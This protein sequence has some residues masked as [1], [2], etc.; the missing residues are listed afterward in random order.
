MPV[1][2]TTHLAPISA[3]THILAYSLGSIFFLFAQ[4]NILCTVITRDVRVTKYYLAILA[5]GDIGHL[6]ANYKGMGP[7]VFWNFGDYNEVMFGNV[8]IT[9]FLW[10]NRIATLAGVFGRVGRRG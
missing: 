10:V 7:N 1:T 5:C 6:Y 3:S 2:P 9:V 8:A 4:I